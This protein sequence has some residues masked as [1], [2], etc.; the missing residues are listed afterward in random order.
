MKNRFETKY[1]TLKREGR[2]QL[3]FADWISITLY[4]NS[5]DYISALVEEVN[6]AMN[7]NHAASILLSYD[8]E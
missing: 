4:D 6:K 7:F 8:Y 5:D 1:G 3:N 2:Q